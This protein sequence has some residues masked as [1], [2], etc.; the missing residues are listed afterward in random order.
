MDNSRGA[1]PQSIVRQVLAFMLGAAHQPPMVPII[2]LRSTKIEILLL[3]P[4]AVDGVRALQLM[5]LS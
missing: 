4:N 2:S 5:S 3:T 1:S